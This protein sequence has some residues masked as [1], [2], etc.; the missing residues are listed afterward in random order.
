MRCEG[1]WSGADFVNIPH[2]AKAL[3][4]GLIR[5]ECHTELHLCTPRWFASVGGMSLGNTVLSEFGRLINCPRVEVDLRPIGGRPFSPKNTEKRLSKI[6]SWYPLDPSSYPC[7]MFP[8]LAYPS[9]CF[10]RESLRKLVSTPDSSIFV[11]ENI[12]LKNVQIDIH[13][14]CVTMILPGPMVLKCFNRRRR[15]N[16]ILKQATHLQ[17][18]EDKKFGPVLQWMRIRLFLISYSPL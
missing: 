13:R 11:A 3:I 12:S 14:C 17:L 16:I 6:S 5:I 7:R 15:C 1:S 10:L 9:W 8:L 4:S 18:A 2:E